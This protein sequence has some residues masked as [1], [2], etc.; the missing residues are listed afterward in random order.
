MLY[1]SQY[2]TSAAVKLGVMISSAQDISKRERLLTTRVA[3]KSL[4]RAPRAR[5]R[6]RQRGP[7]LPVSL[8]GFRGYSLPH[9][10]EEVV[11]TDSKQQILTSFSQYE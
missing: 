1:F 10:H 4:L 7:A 6:E 3:C 2:V 11:S 9:F 5:E 8:F